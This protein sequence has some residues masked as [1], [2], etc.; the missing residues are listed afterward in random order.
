MKYV[1]RESMHTNM[2]VNAIEKG[3]CIRLASLTSRT[4]EN[5]MMSLSDIC[6]DVDKALR[7]ADLLV[8]GKKLPILGQLLD[9]REKEMMITAAK[10]AE[11]KKR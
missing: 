9:N 5:E 1:K 10:V 8:E 3:V 11:R 6:P 4:P 7:V 2:C